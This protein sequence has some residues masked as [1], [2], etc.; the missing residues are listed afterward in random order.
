MNLLSML[1]RAFG[2]EHGSIRSSTLK[3]GQFF[4]VVSEIVTIYP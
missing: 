1:R 4:D 3:T 2:S